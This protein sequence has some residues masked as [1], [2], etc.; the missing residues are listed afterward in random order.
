MKHQCSFLFLLHLY[1]NDIAHKKIGK[2]NIKTVTSRITGFR[3][4][5]NR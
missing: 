1:K 5:Q 3:S 2:K 4:L